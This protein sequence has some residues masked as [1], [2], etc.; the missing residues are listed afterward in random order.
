MDE[1]VDPTSMC[2]KLV[3]SMQQEAAL[4]TVAPPGIRGLFADWMGQLEKEV[5]ALA[6]E[7]QGLTPEILARSFN[8]SIEGS[9]FLVGKLRKEGKI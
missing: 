9:A 3:S 5:L 4:Q 2:R 1:G 6:R 7:H 8:I